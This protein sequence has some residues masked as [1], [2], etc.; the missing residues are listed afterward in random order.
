VLLNVN[1]VLKI[2]DL[3]TLWIVDKRSTSRS[4]P[5]ASSPSSLAREEN[6]IYFKTPEI[7][8]PIVAI[9]NVNKQKLI[10]IIQTTINTLVSPNRNKKIEFLFKQ[11]AKLIEPLTT[12]VP[13]FSSPSQS[14]TTSHQ[15]QQQSSQSDSTIESQNRSIPQTSQKNHEETFHTIDNQINTK[16]DGIT[17]RNESHTQKKI[18]E[19]EDPTNKRRYAKFKFSSTHSN[20]PDCI[21][22]GEW[23]DAEVIFQKQII[24]YLCKGMFCSLTES[25]H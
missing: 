19:V 14:N 10:K 25:D 17:H 20:F 11:L 9:D 15:E 2:Y 3:N 24:L 21:Y 12:T 4:V 6:T 18:N 22:E 13:Q 16:N 7:N 23:L 5:S 1:P 8:C